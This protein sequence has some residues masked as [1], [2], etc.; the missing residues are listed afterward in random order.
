MTSG[1]YRYD[2]VDS[3]GFYIMR[4]DSAFDTSLDYEEYAKKHIVPLL[5]VIALT[6]NTN[7][8]E[9]FRAYWSPV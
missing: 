6:H 5:T 2:I 7:E 1:K 9:D 4:I 8:I 3:E